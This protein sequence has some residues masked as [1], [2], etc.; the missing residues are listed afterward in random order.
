MWTAFHRSSTKIHLHILF[1]YFTL[2]SMR[3]LK[4]KNTSNT[5]NHN[6]PPLAPLPFYH[7]NIHCRSSKPLTLF[8]LI[9][10]M[11]CMSL[12]ISD[13][14]LW[15]NKWYYVKGMINSL[16]LNGVSIDFFSISMIWNVNNSKI[17]YEMGRMYIPMSYFLF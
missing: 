14:M 4:L 7:S 3:A 9:L 13:N 16:E 2:Y 10:L 15:Y 1:T 12:R 11:R 8:V 6:V 5:F 17:F